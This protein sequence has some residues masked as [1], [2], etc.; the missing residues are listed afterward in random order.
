MQAVLHWS[1]RPRNPMDRVIVSPESPMIESVFLTYNSRLR[2]EREHARV[3]CV[4]PPRNG[5]GEEVNLGRL[6]ALGRLHLQRTSPKFCV[7]DSVLKR[8]S[9]CNSKKRRTKQTKKKKQ[10][11]QHQQQAS[12]DEHLY[13]SLSL[14]ETLSSC[15]NES[16]SRSYTSFVGAEVWSLAWMPRSVTPRDDYN[17][18]VVQRNTRSRTP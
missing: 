15:S 10:H 18:S 5:A 1:K 9:N 8:P 14:F 11:Q 4:V 17:R 3:P 7:D 13:Q 16:G 12:E 6:L 2:T